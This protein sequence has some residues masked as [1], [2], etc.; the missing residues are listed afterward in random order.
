MIRVMRNGKLGNGTQRHNAPITAKPRIVIPANGQENDGFVLRMSSAGPRRV[1]ADLEGKKFF[2]EWGIE[3]FEAVQE[4][5]P[6]AVFG[7]STEKGSAMLKALSLMQY[8][9]GVFDSDAVAARKAISD[10]AELLIDDTELQGVFSTGSP[11]EVAN[12]F[13]PAFFTREIRGAQ[14]V[15]WRT[16]QE[17]FLPAIYCPNI[18]TASFVAVAYRGLA[19]CLNC[20]RVFSPGSI[21][22]DDS[23]SEKYC[24][25]A[26]GQRNRQ[27]IYR[28]KVKQRSRSK[29]TARRKGKR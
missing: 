18:K 11:R 22:V 28:L 5:T 3:Q 1:P 8:A 19:A 25:V 10:A 23:S 16:K 29:K 2:A 15:M 24:T 20:Y 13:Y 9:H 4:F 7:A 17:Q 21:S 6:A 12:W 26:C 27:K 14:L